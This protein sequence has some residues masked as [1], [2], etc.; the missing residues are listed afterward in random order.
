MALRLRDRLSEASE[1]ISESA[2]LDAINGDSGWYQSFLS[3]K[4]G[5]N[6]NR[7]VLAGLLVGSWLN[8]SIL[9]DS[10]SPN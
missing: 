6:V 4:K 2:V 9:N 3:R 10:L 8:E 5:K 1:D 7:N